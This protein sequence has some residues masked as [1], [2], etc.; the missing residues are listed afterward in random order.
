MQNVEMD[1]RMKKSEPKATYCRDRDTD[2]EREESLHNHITMIQRQGGRRGPFQHISVP[3][4]L[5]N[6]LLIGI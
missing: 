3:L 6:N 5:I 2:R 1:R 4:N